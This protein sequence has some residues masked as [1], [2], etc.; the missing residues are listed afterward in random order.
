MLCTS[1]WL[2]RN[3]SRSQWTQPDPYSLRISEC[4]CLTLFLVSLVQSF[5][6]IFLFKIPL[7]YKVVNMNPVN[8][9]LLSEKTNVTNLN[10]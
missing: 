7:I 4:L 2:F 1:F 3:Q 6:L 5:A 9:Y 8:I 10:T